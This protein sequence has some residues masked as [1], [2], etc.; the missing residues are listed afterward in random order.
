MLDTISDDPPCVFEPKFICNRTVPGEWAPADEPCNATLFTDCD[1]NLANMT[2]GVMRQTIVNFSNSPVY[3]FDRTGK[4]VFTSLPTGERDEP[5]IRTLRASMGQ[6]PRNQTDYFL[7]PDPF[8]PDTPRYGSREDPYLNTVSKDQV[9]GGKRVGDEYHLDPRR[10]TASVVSKSQRPEDFG[11]ELIIR[12]RKVDPVGS[13]LEGSGSKKNIVA[14]TNGLSRDRRIAAVQKWDSVISVMAIERDAR[15]FQGCD[16]LYHEGLDLWIS[17]NKESKWVG[18]IAYTQQRSLTLLDEE[19]VPNK[20]APVV[21]FHRKE[22]FTGRGPMIFT[23]DRHTMFRALMVESMFVPEGE[24]RIAVTAVEAADVSGTVPNI[25]YIDIS[26]SNLRMADYQVIEDN[27]N[28]LIAETAQIL[29]NYLQS[30]PDEVD[31]RLR[32]AKPEQDGYVALATYNRDLTMVSQQSDNDRAARKL[33]QEQTQALVSE[34]TSSDRPTYAEVLKRLQ[35][36]SQSPT[37]PDQSGKGKPDFTETFEKAKEHSST[38]AAFMKNA[39]EIIL[40]AGVI[41]GA[42]TT[43][44]LWARGWFSSTTEDT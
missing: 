28:F 32:T 20:I 44:V 6:R 18:E 1:A 7:P 37:R 4:I 12:L 35:Q 33:M 23:L 19:L 10:H 38:F 24:I 5:I 9:L 13:T 21:V 31:A 15:E 36:I 3:F 22:D 42:L 17:T 2:A 27:R 11:S 43:A 26:L 29:Q 14:A 25:R 40:A 39:K 8:N 41:I 34:M 16:A 30:D